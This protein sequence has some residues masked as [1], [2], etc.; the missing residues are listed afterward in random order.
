[1]IE[2]FK[3]LDQALTALYDSVAEEVKPFFTPII[4]FLNK[5]LTKPQ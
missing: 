4:E 2:S 5:I 3:K 1:M